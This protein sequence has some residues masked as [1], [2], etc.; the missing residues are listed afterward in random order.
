MP[1][2]LK[3]PGQWKEEEKKTAWGKEF[4]HNR[5][6]AG[7]IINRKVNKVE[8]TKT[9]IVILGVFFLINFV[10]CKKKEMEIPQANLGRGINLGNALE[11]PQEGEWGIVIQEYFFDKI[12][13]VGFKAVRIPIRW[14]AH[15]ET[16]F[17]YTINESFFQRVDDVINQALARNLNVIINIHHFDELTEDPLQ[18]EDKLYQIWRQITE[19]YSGFPDK[20]I[21]ELLNEPHEALTSDLWNQFIINLL[22]IIREANPERS[23]IIGPVQWNSISGLDSLILPQDQNLIATFHY[24]S[25][26]SFTHQ[27][28]EWVEGSDSWLGTIWEGTE[29]EM[30]AITNDLNKAVRWAARNEI[31]LFMGEFGAY[32]KADYES[33]IRWTRFLAREA[34]KRD[35]SWAYWEFGAG[36]GIYDIEND[37]WDMGILNALIPHV[38]VFDKDASPQSQSR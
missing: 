1:I 26:F 6:Q 36:F 8:T 21:F 24:Y 12:K 32:Y 4:S 13:D 22:E 35:I 17:P 25:P 19:R 38:L 10:T 20:L 30:S 23:V 2:T 16:H 37:E 33:R 28:A 31:P 9:I 14:S 27:G 3:K 18:H 7:K 15:I 11:A 34:E 29:S 5:E